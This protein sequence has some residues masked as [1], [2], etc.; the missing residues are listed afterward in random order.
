MKNIFY[1]SPDGNDKNDGN[2]K[3]PWATLTGAR[4]AIREI[5][6]N[7][8]LKEKEIVVILKPGIYRISETIQFS[9][10]DSYTTYR[11][12]EKGSA[13][14]DASEEISGFREEKLNGKTVWTA[15]LPEVK[16]G[17]RYFR[18][19]FVNG[20]SRPRARLPKFSPDKDGV[21]NLFRIGELRF[22]EKK[23][24]FDGDN[25]FKPAVGDFKNWESLPDAEI[26]ILHYWIETRLGNPRYDEKSGWVTCSRRSVFNLYEPHNSKLARYYIDNL[27]E[28]MTEP[29][30]WY[31]DRN[32]GKLFYIPKQGE[33]LKNTKICA[34]LTKVFLKI[35]GDAYH[36]GQVVHDILGVQHVENLKFEGLHFRNSDWYQPLADFLSHDR[37]RLEEFPLGSAPQG[38]THVPG[39]IEMRWCKKCSI[40]ETKLENIGLTAIAIEEGCRNC[41]VSKSSISGIGAGGIR[42]GGC[43]LDGPPANRTGYIK[44]SDNKITNIGRIFQQGVGIL[45]TN[46]FNC[47]V[48]HNEIS[49]TCYTGIS[50]GWSWGYRETI[51]RNNLIE[52]NLIYDI[53]QAVLSDMGGIYLLGVQPGTVVRGNHIHHVSSAE[54][55]GWGIYPD[56]GSSHILIE[57][58]WVH[59]IQGSPFRIHFSREL[60]VRDNVFAR[61]K[62]EGLIGIGKIENHIAANIHGN[63]LIGPA[64]SVFECGYAGNLTEAFRSDANLIWF[65]EN[66][67]L[68]FGNYPEYRTDCK[69]ISYEEWLSSGNDRRSIIEDPKAIETDNDISFPEN[70]PIEKIG[71]KRRSWK[72]CGPR[73]NEK[74]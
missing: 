43:E 7:N 15:Q 66:K 5:R 70:S 9:P 62:K 60:V 26:V 67:I 54:Y 3:Y 55:G 52:N 22:P 73:Q 19:L 42:V 39:A 8:E 69:K 13:I 45:L 35:N 1:I 20:E 64:S 25:I 24:L 61:S 14:L 40:T 56:E 18:S 12:E 65:P 4:D 74:N 16:A 34:P 41:E 57:G 6:K 53:G 49:K 11:A 32:E 51:S 72:N 38:A 37:Q 17:R 36:H 21:K 28:A 33:T 29:G 50:C 46:A 63:V 27:K 10:I 44:I 68:S 47:N 30:E 31:L 2:E 48:N 58:N 59:D 71:F 23:K